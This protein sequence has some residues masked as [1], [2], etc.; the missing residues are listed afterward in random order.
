MSAGNFPDEELQSIEE[1]DGIESK[2]F[3]EILN[4]PTGSPSTLSF[5][6]EEAGS[7]LPTSKILPT[8]QAHVREDAEPSQ[9]VRGAAKEALE[10]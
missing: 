3:L 10:S 7:A 2:S 9:G 8:L 4:D 5:I 6:A 1:L